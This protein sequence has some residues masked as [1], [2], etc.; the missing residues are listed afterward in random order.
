MIMLRMQTRF[1]LR[2]SQEFVSEL[3]GSDEFDTALSRSREMKA[4][5]LASRSSLT[6]SR[7]LSRLQAVSAAA[8]CGRSLRLP[9]S[10][11]G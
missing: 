8:S 7:P 9:L 11:F 6:T 5:L 2:E 1:D 10:F 4:T 3:S